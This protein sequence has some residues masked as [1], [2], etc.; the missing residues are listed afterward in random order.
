[1]VT[2]VGGMPTTTCS[3][4]LESD[5]VTFVP[6]ETIAVSVT[7]SV[8]DPVEM[9][10]VFVTL[11]DE[12]VAGIVHFRTWYVDVPL[13]TVDNL[14]PLAFGSRAVT[15]DIVTSDLRLAY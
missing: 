15:E 3:P 12:V 7:G 10:R 2:A 14:V 6:P 8:I 9:M 1:M 11:G 5:V 4:H 13:T